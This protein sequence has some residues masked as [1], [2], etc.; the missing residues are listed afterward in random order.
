M[1]PM[2]CSKWVLFDDI[3]WILEQ[4]PKRQHTALFSA[5]MPKP[6]Q[7]IA[8]KYLKNPKQ[9][10]IQACAKQKNHIKQQFIITQNKNKF[11]K[12]SRILETTDTKS[13][14]IFTKTKALSEQVTEL[15]L[16]K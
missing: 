7:K 14:I 4:L 1:K 9:I 5:T 6:I 11:T 16:K 2:K 12:L 10:A 3:K 8:L 15:L 13:I